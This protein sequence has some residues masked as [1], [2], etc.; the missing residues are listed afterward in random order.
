[1]SQN[2]HN[3]FSFLNSIY[4]DAGMVI[5]DVGAGAGYHTFHLS[6]MVGQSGKVF[7]IDVQSDVLDQ[8]SKRAQEGGFENIKTIL[9]DVESKKGISLKDGIIDLALVSNI[10]FQL[11]DKDSAIKEIKRIL[12]PNGKIIFVD[13]KISLNQKGSQAH[14]IFSEDEAHEFF[15]KHELIHVSDIHAGTHH[16]GKLIR[17]KT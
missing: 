17:K 4:A 8:I 3:P 13:W 1:M 9:A 2:F 12:K 11:S 15:K 14:V 10:F 7:A 6:T 16:Y 5:A